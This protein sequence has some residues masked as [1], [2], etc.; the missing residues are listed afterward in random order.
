MRFLKS[1]YILFPRDK[2]MESESKVL[3]RKRDRVNLKIHQKYKNKGNRTVIILGKE[4]KRNI[5]DQVLFYGRR[6]NPPE[7]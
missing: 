6:Y 5:L 4:D 2:S 1:S 3:S 7:R